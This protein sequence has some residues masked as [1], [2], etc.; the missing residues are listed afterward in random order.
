MQMGDKLTLANNRPNGY[1]VRNELQ[2]FFS[3][4]NY[5]YKDK[6]GTGPSVKP[7]PSLYVEPATEAWIKHR[8]IRR[9]RALQKAGQ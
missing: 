9:A 1:A 4:V 3:R 6:F 7:M 8:I 5:S 2:S